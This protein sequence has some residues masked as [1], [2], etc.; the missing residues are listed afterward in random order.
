MLKT[1][2]KIEIIKETE[3]TIETTTE[4]IT[5]TTVDNK[6]TKTTSKTEEKKTKPKKIVK[7][8]QCENC[9]NC[10]PNS[11]INVVDHCGRCGQ[12]Y[13][14]CD[15]PRC[16]EAIDKEIGRAGSCVYYSR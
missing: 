14:Y 11:H 9:L 8:L 15:S 13:Y 10:E 3:T 7:L 12:K 6:T 5:E 4:I 2:T 16:E 1:T